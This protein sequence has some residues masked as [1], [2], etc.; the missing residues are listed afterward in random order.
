[1]LRASRH[2]DSQVKRGE[3]MAAL[4]ELKADR[5]PITFRRVARGCR[6]GWS[7][8]GAR[9]WAG[10]LIQSFPNELDQADAAR[11]AGQI[12]STRPAFE[13]L[14][15]ADWS[16]KVRSRLPARARSPPAPTS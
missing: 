5:Q 12:R 8:P 14:G 13:A 7:M 4:E 3:V 11:L 1:M 2:K 16:A 15:R 6:P 9:T 10:L